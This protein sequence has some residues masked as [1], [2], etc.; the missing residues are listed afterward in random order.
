MLDDTLKAPTCPFRLID[1]RQGVT[2]AAIIT[3]GGAQPHAGSVANAQTVAIQHV[4]QPTGAPTLATPSTGPSATLRAILA[5]YDKWELENDPITAGNEG[6]EAS[7]FRLPDVTPAA[8][9]ARRTALF[10]FQRRLLTLKSARLKD[11]DSLNRDLLLRAVSDDLDA[12][13][14]D[15]Q[16]QP[17]TAY[18]S[19]SSFGA[20]LANATVIRSKLEADAYLSR[21]RALPDYYDQELANARRGLATGFIQP[22]LVV[23]VALRTARKQA[24]ATPQESGLM[25]PFDKLPSTIAPEI[26]AD[27]RAQ[28]LAVVT[29]RVLPAQRRI[30][31]FLET[32]YL[33]RARKSLAAR[34][35]PDGERYYVA[36]VRRHTT[37]NLTP[38]Q[39][40][41]IG[42]DEVSRIRAEMDK[43]IAEVGFKGDFSAFIT[44]LRTDPKF[45]AHTR[46]ELLLYYRD[47]AK[48]IDPEL[49][50]LFGRLPRLTYGVKPIPEA[51]EEGQTTAY[52]QGGSPNRGVSGTFAVNLSHLDQ[53]PLYEAPTLALHEA[54]PGHHLQ[55][56]LSQEQTDTPAFRKHLEFTAFVEGWGLY[57]E[58][59]GSEIGLYS[60]PYERFGQLS[61][62]MWRACRLVADTG[63]HWKRWTREQARACFM[64]N[65]ALSEHNIDT[66]VD[67]YISWPGQAL[68][69]KIGELRIMGL[70]KKA[71]ADLGAG[72]DE[73]RFHDAVLL[74]GALPLDLLETR[75]NAWILREKASL[76]AT[77]PKP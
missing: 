58:Q 27:L 36:Q 70:R 66:E 76:K 57:A 1:I 31:S 52:Y 35:L 2:L 48:R 47:I 20:S 49:P 8:N 65:T 46:E 43:I 74:S 19:F 18:W 75:V 22:R 7:L 41:Q 30:A 9:D 72:F 73:R 15:L 29:D 62:E 17:F 51:T 42:L 26:Q 12:A 32:E 10:E 37:T 67:R 28:L 14:F 45:Y 11:A 64:E 56:A 71:E 68:A 3:L 21:L 59:L 33:P 44:Y 50:R 6:D 38:D 34:D 63:I 24:S 54:V 16:R 39:V 77:S 61:Y 23:E 53:R 5:D 55:I 40:H 13:Q 69:Y 60:T 4:A 25:K